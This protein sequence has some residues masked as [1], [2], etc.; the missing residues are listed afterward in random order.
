MPWIR[1]SLHGNV[2]FARCRSDGTV[3]ADETGRVDVKYK[4]DAAAKVYR[5]TAANLKV[6]PELEND[7][8]IPDEEVA[9]AGGAPA[10]PAAP[11]APR[12]AAATKASPPSSS[13][14]AAA[15][16]PARGRTAAGPPGANV[17][18]YTDG[19]C[20]GN[21]GPMG[22]GVVVMADGKRKEVSE[23][24]G[25]GTNN[26]AELTAIERGLEVVEQL[27]RETG[28]PLVERPVLVHSDS[29]YAIG[30]LSQNWRAKANAELVARLRELAR[31]FPR[32]R[33]V[34]VAGHA[35]VPENERCDELA[36]AA[37]VSRREASRMTPG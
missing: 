4:P 36:R 6:T 13:A 16:P 28:E 31:R 22:I 29:A 23:Y 2:V 21:P 17:I 30:L 1:R 15:A 14:A 20:T 24:L 27:A 33:F 7:R 19:A 35:G 12:A 37:V 3:A 11:A 5:A 32:L 34:K 25:R 9:G 26:I 10:A 18:V 8:P